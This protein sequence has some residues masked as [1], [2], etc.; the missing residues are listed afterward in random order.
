MQYPTITCNEFFQIFFPC[1]IVNISRY[2]D[3]RIKKKK[4]KR[5]RE[6]KGEK[7]EEKWEKGWNIWANE[8]LFARHVNERFTGDV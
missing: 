1:S 7:K 4:K 5:E 3:S 8:R 6:E 2:R